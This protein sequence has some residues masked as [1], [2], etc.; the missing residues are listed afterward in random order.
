MEHATLYI[1]YSERTSGGVTY[2]RVHYNARVE[3]TPPNVRGL[4]GL[5]YL[6]GSAYGSGAVGM[7]GNPLSALADRANLVL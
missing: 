4:R 7:V 5:H 3:H 6:H 1:I 2:L